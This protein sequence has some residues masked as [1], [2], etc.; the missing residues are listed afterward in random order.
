M[1]DH[2]DKSKMS[3]LAKLYDKTVMAY[4]IPVLILVTA[5]A[6]FFGYQAQ[7]FT[8]DASSDAIVLEND[9]DLK[10]YDETR[11]MFGSDDYVFITLKPAN[12]DL[13]SQDTLEP[14][15][16]MLDELAALPDVESVTSI[17]NVPLFHSPDVPLMNLA[18]GYKSLET[19]ADPELARVEMT[20]SPLYKNYLINE[21]GT[22]TAMQV[23]FKED[24][25]EFKALDKR[26]TDLKNQ[27]KRK[28]P[29]GGGGSG[30]STA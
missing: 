11:E 20:T 26:R 18:N 21:E 1:T 19:G 2:F 16:K 12:G 24:P 4:P 29:F 28:R 6:V 30:I 3:G 13:F 22:T 27:K 15:A 14:M 10:Y 7:Y 9:R 5:L 25:P 17:L 8:L 23:T